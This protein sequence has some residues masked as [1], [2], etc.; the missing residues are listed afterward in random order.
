MQESP[1]LDSTL[2]QHTHQGNSDSMG[3]LSNQ[4]KERAS[5]LKGTLTRRSLDAETEIEESSRIR[6]NDPRALRIVRL[7]R[8]EQKEKLDLDDEIEAQTGKKSR[9]GSPSLVSTLH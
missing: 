6:H 3:N 7:A 5:E 2:P 8:K 1:R 4:E 9:K